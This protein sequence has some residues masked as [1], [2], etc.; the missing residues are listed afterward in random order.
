MKLSEAYS[1]SI[2]FMHTGNLTGGPT[3]A[4]P[5]TAS[6]TAGVLG[7]TGA[8]TFSM[9]KYG[10][11]CDTAGVCYIRSPGGYPSGPTKTEAGKALLNTGLVSW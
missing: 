10:A 9:K 1:T 8:P 6:P 3:T 4:S 5:T 11:G 2:A 7:T